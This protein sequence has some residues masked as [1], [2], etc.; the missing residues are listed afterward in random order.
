MAAVN[1]PDDYSFL[2]YLVKIFASL[3]ALEINFMS[4]LHPFL[5]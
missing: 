5:C 2:K 1:E 4:A 3:F